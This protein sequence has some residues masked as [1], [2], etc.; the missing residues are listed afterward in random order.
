MVLLGDIFKDR[1]KERIDSLEKLLWRI[2][3]PFF[4]PHTLFSR[5]TM[6]HLEISDAFTTS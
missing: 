2:T 3:S 5:A 4:S 6:V 1:K